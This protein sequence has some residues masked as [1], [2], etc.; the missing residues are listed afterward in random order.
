MTNQSFEGDIMLRTLCLL[1]LLASST[2]MQAHSDNDSLAH[3]AFWWSEN[4]KPILDGNGQ[5]IRNGSWE[6]LGKPNCITESTDDAAASPAPVAPIPEV[7]E[8]L[9]TKVEVVTE[10]SEEQTT[11]IGAAIVVAEPVLAAPK[12]EP[13]AATPAATPTPTPTPAPAPAST[14]TPDL[15]PEPKAS[16]VTYSYPVQLITTHILFDFDKNNLRVDQQ[17]KIE[18]VLIKARKAYNIFKVSLG[19]H[20]DSRGTDHYNYDLSQRRINTAV[21]YLNLRGMQTDTTMAWGESQLI[22]NADGSENY[23]LSRRVELVIK[24]QQKIAD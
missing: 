1:V 5:C 22:T 21:N 24:V 13:A 18:L 3:R 7:K 15:L 19:G 9:E 8:I 2:I 23:D 16:A 17:E 20:A 12:A 10:V 4:G 14:P 6:A 11:E